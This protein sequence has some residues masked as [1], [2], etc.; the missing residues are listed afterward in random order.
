MFEIKYATNGIDTAN[1]NSVYGK[2]IR[3]VTSNSNVLDVGCY[4]G[5]T[6]AALVKEKACTVT[7][8]D[9]D[10]N[11]LELAKNK[12]VYKD[13]KRIDLNDFEISQIIDQQGIFDFILLCDVLEHIYEPNNLLQKLKILLKPEGI[14]IISV[15]NIAHGGIKLKLLNNL[16]EYTK[17]GL[18]DYTHIKFFTLN[19]LVHM[20][21]NN[22][23]LIQK[24]ERV[25]APL[26][27]RGQTLDLHSYPWG[28]IKYV[29]DNNES[30]TYQYYA[31]C[32]KTNDERN[33]INEHNLIK[34]KY[35]NSFRGQH[36]SFVNFIFK[37]FSRKLCV[38]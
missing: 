17:T 14:I 6:G 38:R 35:N 18:L 32:K 13:L 10:E 29:S 8:V 34:S 23:L 24:M 3:D 31:V 25:Y 26:D 9:Y 33:M 37:K 15:P 27:D 12:N 2:V 4:A 28:I 20:L 1:L 19:S 5:E 16:F 22:G 11:A 30:F 21:N 36:I 7:G